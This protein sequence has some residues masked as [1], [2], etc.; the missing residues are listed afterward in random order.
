MLSVLGCGSHLTSTNLWG[1]V[2]AFIPPP[3]PFI[4]S[5]AI[6]H[7]SLPRLDGHVPHVFPAAVNQLLSC[8]PWADGLVGGGG[9]GGCACVDTLSDVADAG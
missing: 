8:H 4:S 2:H 5:R 7:G 3:R 6:H 9:G 1:I